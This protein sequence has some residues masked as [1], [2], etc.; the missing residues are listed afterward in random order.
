MSSKST[1]SLRIT[2]DMR[3]RL[4]REAE[5]TQRSRAH[6][7]QQALDEHFDRL[8]QNA[9]QQKRQGRYSGLLGLQGAAI[10]ATGPRT[11][12]DIDDYIRWLRDD[13]RVSE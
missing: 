5:E 7:V 3:N 12:Q 2:R 8:E 6:I 1:L 10:S 11:K 4:D 13:D 9:S